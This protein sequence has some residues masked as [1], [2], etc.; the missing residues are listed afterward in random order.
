MRQ[1]LERI[2]LWGNPYLD[3]QNTLNELKVKF[4]QN[5]AAIQSLVIADAAELALRAG[6]CSF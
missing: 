6:G 5:C 1:M 4:E 2:Q 3:I